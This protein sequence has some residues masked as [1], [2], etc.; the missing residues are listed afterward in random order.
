MKNRRNKK[1]FTIVELVVV[2]G[3]I[4]ILSAILIP[5]FVSLNQKAENAKLQSNLHNA[6]STYALDAAD[7]KVGEDGA[8][9]AYKDQ[10][11]VY[12]TDGANWYH[13]NEAGYWDAASSGSYTAVATP[14]PSYL[15]Y[16]FYF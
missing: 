5:T 1:G 9:L 11:V 7:G 13:W 6:Y 8:A 15:G 4:G 3:V 16:S 2:I 10:N 14:N 12:V